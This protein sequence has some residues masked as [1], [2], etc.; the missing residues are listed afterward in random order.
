EFDFR[1]KIKGSYVIIDM[2]QWYKRDIGKRFYLYHTVNTS[3]QLEKLPK[4]KKPISAL[5]GRKIKDYSP[6]EPVITLVWMSTDNFGFDENYIA[7]VMTPEIVGEFVRNEKL[8]SNSDILEIMKERTAVLKALNNKKKDLDFL[9]QNRLIFAFQG[10][11]VRNK[12]HARYERWFTFAEKSRNEENA[13]SDFDEY[14]NDLLFQEIIRRLEK[15]KLK[16]ND[17]EYIE[18]EK[19]YWFEVVQFDRS[20]YEEGREEEKRNIARNLKLQNLSND[21]IS[22]ATGLSIADIEKL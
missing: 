8:W 1:C 15:R 20:S 16:K 10:N 4:E 19:K 12:T 18:Q 11:I 6:L 22:E 17:L 2:Q 7:Y 13:K 14:K 21:K 9:P 5:T 3:L